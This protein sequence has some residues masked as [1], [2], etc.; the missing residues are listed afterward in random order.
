MKIARW[1]T[2][3]G[4][5]VIFL[6]GIGHGLKLKDIDAMIPA[7]GLHGPLEGILKGCWLV[8]SGEMVGLGVITS[9]ASFMPGG[10]RIVLL[11]AITMGFNAALLIHF[12]GVAKPI[13]IT[14]FVTVMWLA[15]GLLQSRQTA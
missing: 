5:L 6:V 14:L 15:G 7:S 13:Y 11:S 1:L 4:S 12:V 10:S 2:G 9:L 3:I 8:F